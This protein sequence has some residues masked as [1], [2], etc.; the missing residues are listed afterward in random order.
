MIYGDDFSYQIDKDTII[1]GCCLW[2]DMNK[3]NPL[4]MN[5][6]QGAMND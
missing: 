6:A 3:E 5:Y 1:I 2:T 4:F